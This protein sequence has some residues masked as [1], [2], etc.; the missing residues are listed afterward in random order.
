MTGKKAAP[1]GTAGPSRLEVLHDL[2]PATAHARLSGYLILHT[3]KGTFDIDTARGTVVLN[4]RA[5]KAY[6]VVRE[7]YGGR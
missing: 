4:P 6:R 3:Q 7:A 1:A 2:E 5:A